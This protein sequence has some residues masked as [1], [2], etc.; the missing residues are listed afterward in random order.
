MSNDG[1][2]RF[3]RKVKAGIPRDWMG[4]IR[5]TSRILMETVKGI[6]RTGWINIAIVTT[7]AAILVI[8]GSLFRTTLSMTEFVKQL[9]S[10]LE[11]SVYL[12]PDVSPQHASARIKELEHVEKITIISKES[13]WNKMKKDLDVADM[14]N[15]LPDTLHVRVDKPENIKPVYE[16]I[17]S[18]SGVEDLSY[19]QDIAKKM[20]TFSAVTNTITVFVVIIAALLTV[21]SLTIKS[22]VNLI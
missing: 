12:K 16:Q 7:M 22:S 4:E 17:S 5:L 13:A 19:A 1:S 8:F 15:P 10:T 3:K 20:A 11:I 2:M 18:M 6:Y 14:Q 21:M 9:G